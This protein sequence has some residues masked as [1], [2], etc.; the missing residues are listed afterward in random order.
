MS[1]SYKRKMISEDNKRELNSILVGTAPILFLGAGF[2]LGAASK[3]AVMDGKGI[4]EY[5]LTTLV[6]DKVSDVDYEEIK[7]YDL[8]RVCEEV[9]TI[10]NGKKELNQILTSSFINTMPM[11][12]KFHLKLTS[13]P[14]RRI[15][16]VNI[17]DLVE[18]IYD[19]NNKK[20][21]VQNKS[22]LCEEPSEGVILYKLHGCVNNPNEGY[23]F[24]ESDYTDL[25]SSQVDSK[26]MKFTDELLNNNIIFVGASLD[27]PDIK[28]YLN[29]YQ[30]AGY[31]YR[32]NKIVF[33]NPA[34]NRSARGVI[35]KL[36]ASLVEATTEEFLEYIDELNYRPDEVDKA[37]YDMNYHGVHR[38]TD[39]ERNLFTQPYESKLYFG[40]FSRWQDAAEEWIFETESYKNAIEEIKGLISEN[41]EI[42]CFGLYGSLYSG[43]SCMLKKIGYYLKS[44]DFDVLEY[45]GKKLDIDSIWKYMSLVSQNKIAIII[46]NGSFYYEQIEKMFLFPIKDKQ[47]IIVTAS[48]EYYHK[49]KKYYLI[50]NSFV[51]FE[52]NSRFTKADAVS[53][54]NKLDEKSFLSFLSSRKDDYKISYVYKKHNMINFIICLTYGDVASRIKEKYKQIIPKLS[55]IEQKLLLELSLFDLADIE[56]YPRLLFVERYGSAVNLGSDIVINQFGIVDFAR[57]DENGLS[58]KNAM[59]NQLILNLKKEEISKSIIELLKCISKHV[60]EKNMDIWYSIFQRLLKEDILVNRFKLPIEEIENIFLSVKPN[61]KSISYYWLQMGLLFQRKQDYASA[62]IYLEKSASIRPNSF[63]IQH[64]L[65]RNYMRNANASNDFIRATDLFDKGEQMM[66][67]LINSHDYYMDRAKP[68]SVTC[69]ISEKIKF[70]NKFCID[71]SK[72]DLNYMASALDSVKNQQD[73]YVETVFGKFYNFL[74]AHNQLGILHM[75]LDSP[76]MRYI[77]ATEVDISFDDSYDPVV[78]SM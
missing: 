29:V 60:A 49:K 76:Y 44:L 12:N 65:A 54:V 22:A 64:A 37:I 17:D 38:L 55:E 16:T 77:N 5:I 43:K 40:N 72:N 30:K 48:R 50:G 52:V 13:Y 8:R 78:E 71:P 19:I 56:S 1:T 36:G 31:K 11:G 61:Y 63:K 9:I 27:E 57:M 41:K 7:D 59:L 23:I 46:D 68:F 73:K 53:I 42:S 21:F 66:K 10:Y 4:K 25:I 3:T 14:W 6:R 58:L 39:I 47:I 51:D 28:Y 20:C 74:K 34:P 2:S 26:M 62:R 35:K 70:F 24:A 18:N 45:N 67:E 69:Y 75:S 32:N 33:I 15:Y